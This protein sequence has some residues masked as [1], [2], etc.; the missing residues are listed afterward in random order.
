MDFLSLIPS[1]VSVL[2]GG[3]D[4]GQNGS[5]ATYSCTLTN[6]WSMK[7]HPVEYDT[8]TNSA[9]WSPPVLVAHGTDYEMWAPDTLAS[10]GVEIVAESGKT[11]TL[12]DEIKESQTIGS[13]GE[14]VV[15]N[16][17]FNAND[18]P[19]TF[20]DIQLTSNFPMLSTITMAAPSPDWFTGIYNFSPIH[21]ELNVWYESFEIATY[22]FDAGTELGDT[23]SLNNSPQEP[24]IPIFQLTNETIPGDNGIL[25]DESET[26]VRPM[27]LWN[28]IIQKTTGPEITIPVVNENVED[29]DLTTITTDTDTGGDSDGEDDVDSDSDGDGEGDNAGGDGDVDGVGVCGRYFNECTV[30]GDCCSGSCQREKCRAKSRGSGRAESSR[31]SSTGGNTVGGAAGLSRRSSVGTGGGRMKKRFLRG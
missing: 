10:P 3:G 9:H 15:G 29:E 5:A 20:N 24:H 1:T 14:Y 22:P 23:Y 11:L 25:L 17:Q 30:N 2:A 31:I 13:A 12:E 27:A 8:I 7:N 18:P 19:Q 4:A 6:I 21:P 16:N 28:C 26:V